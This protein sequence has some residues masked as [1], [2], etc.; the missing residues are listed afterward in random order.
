MATS[1]VVRVQVRYDQW[2]CSEG[3]AVAARLH[4]GFLLCCGWQVEQ[5]RT[6]NW[7]TRSLLE[8]DSMCGCLVLSNNPTASIPHDAPCNARHA[9]VL[10][11]SEN[12]MLVI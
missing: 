2:Q 12:L 6:R 8:S 7:Q 10:Q 9:V 3:P 11:C 1:F 4:E 5:M